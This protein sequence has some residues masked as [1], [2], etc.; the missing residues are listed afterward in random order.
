MISVKLIDKDTNKVCFGLKGINAVFAN[1]LRRNILERVPTMAIEEVEFVK[2][3]SIFFKTSFTPALTLKISL[4]IGRIT[5]P[6]C[7]LMKVAMTYFVP[8]TIFS[9]IFL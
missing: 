7:L 6:S 4:L 9:L 8:S 3:S 5:S 1:T 2:N